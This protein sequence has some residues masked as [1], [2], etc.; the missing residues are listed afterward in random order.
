MIVFGCAVTDESTFDRCFR[1]GY[2]RAAEADSML[3][4]DR[5]GGSVSAGYNRILERV[6]ALDGVEAVVLVHQ[7][8]EILSADFCARVRAVLADP[9]VGLIGG[10]GSTEVAGLDWWD[11]GP[12]VGSYDW[13]YDESG[14]RVTMESWDGFREAEGIVEVEAVDG[15][16]LVMPGPVARSLRFDAE[17]DPSAH[18]YDIDLSF[19][20]RDAG[21]KVVVASLG[22]AHHH[23]LV[24]LSEPTGWIE[25]HQ[26]LARKWEGRFSVPDGG[27]WEER[28]RL[29]EAQRAAADI[30]RNQL[31]M[32]RN[33]A[34]E[35]ALAAERRATRA[36]RDAEAAR[37]AAS[38]PK[39]RL[40]A[41]VGNRL[42]NSAA[43]I[44]ASVRRRDPGRGAAE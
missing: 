17:I 15:M 9:R 30:A 31:S 39:G 7:D 21:L 26:R 5:D 28:A 4:E 35:R 13:I 25:A 20:V 12:I 16:I 36:E 23:G 29:A 33:A 18:G 44:R 37:D 41:V 2:D 32:L 19:Q 10:A 8:L 34:D 24:V 14:S 3:I 6:G 22:I 11:P 43:A 38:T 42:Y 1:P 27:R 40:R